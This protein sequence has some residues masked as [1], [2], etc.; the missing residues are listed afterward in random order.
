MLKISRFMGADGPATAESVL[1]RRRY[2]SGMSQIVYR[3]YRPKRT[4]PK[5]K[6]PAPLAIPAVVKYVPHKRRRIDPQDQPEDT[7]A[8]RRAMQW[9]LEQLRSPGS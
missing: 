3:P 2:I 5:K 4:P 8:S 1:V 7:E 9:I 6:A